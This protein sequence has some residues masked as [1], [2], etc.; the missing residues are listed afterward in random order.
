MS[1]P[2]RTPEP[3]PIWFFVGVILATYGLIVL[4]A[5]LLGDPRPTVLQELRP[6]LW[7]GGIMIFSGAVFTLIGLVAHRRARAA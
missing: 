4:V 3:L 2:T 6:N 7:W 1:E 5:G